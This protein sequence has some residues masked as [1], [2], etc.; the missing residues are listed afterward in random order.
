MAKCKTVSAKL[1]KHEENLKF[2]KELVT[3]EL[4]KMAKAILDKYDEDY[5]IIDHKQCQEHVLS[6]KAETFDTFI[7]KAWEIKNLAI[8]N[9][10]PSIFGCQEYYIEGAKKGIL[11]LIVFDLED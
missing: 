3:E 11:K 4:T 10:C 1:T 2:F 5:Y 7:E 6:L 9:K 8:A